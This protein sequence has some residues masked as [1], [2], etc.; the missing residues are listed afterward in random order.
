ME[1]SSL[2]GVTGDGSRLRRADAATK[3]TFVLC[4]IAW[5]SNVGSMY[6]VSSMPLPVTRYPLFVCITSSH[7]LSYWPGLSEPG[8]PTANHP[9]AGR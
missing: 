4:L 6:L 7:V 5:G 9:P 1:R 8:F 2:V 3:S